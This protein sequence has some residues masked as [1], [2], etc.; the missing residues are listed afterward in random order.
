MTE[1]EKRAASAVDDRTRRLMQRTESLARDQLASLHGTV[2]SLHRVPE[3]PD[4]WPPIEKNSE[5]EEKR[6]NEENST[7]LTSV[8]VGGAEVRPGDHVRLRP[9]PGGDIFDLALKDHLATIESIEQD[10]E[11]RVY[12]AVTVDDDPGQDFG[13][14]KQPGHRF[15]F[16]PDEVELV[17]AAA[18]QER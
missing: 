10:F 14:A 11:N 15:F 5:Y 6:E 1:E 12:L 4:T 13:R 2:R 17:G 9:R 16:K 3:V 7:P 18:G 8:R